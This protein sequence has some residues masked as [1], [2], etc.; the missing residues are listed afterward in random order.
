MSGCNHK[1]DLRYQVMY[2]LKWNKYAFADLVL[3][4]QTKKLVHDWPKMFV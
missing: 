3:Q 2:F 4:K 1:F